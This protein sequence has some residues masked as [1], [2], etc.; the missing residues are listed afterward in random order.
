[1]DNTHPAH[2]ASQKATQ[3]NERWVHYGMQN[4]KTEQNKE[5]DLAVTSCVWE[6]QLTDLN[7][8]ITN[9]GHQEKENN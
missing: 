9:F 5:S 2:A 8:A 6:C 3:I 4:K 7:I 1:M